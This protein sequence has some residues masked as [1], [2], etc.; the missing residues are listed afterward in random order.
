MHFVGFK[1]LSILSLFVFLFTTYIIGQDLDGVRL[2]FGVGSSIYWGS[3]MDTKIVTNTLGKSEIN[4]GL[5][6]QIYKSFDNINEFGIRFLSSELWS[7]KS[8]NQLALNNQFKELSFL[9]QRSLNQNVKLNNGPLTVNLLAGVGVLYYSASFYTINNNNLRIF[10]SIGAG[11]KPVSD[12]SF[13]IKEKIP[14]ISGIIG[15]NLGFK[16]S[17]RL[18]LYLENS[19]SLS[20]DN[21]FTGNLSLKSKVPNNGFTYH[22]LSLYLNWGNQKGRIGCPKF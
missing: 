11:D 10:S 17:P 21:R 2:G 5:N 7:F 14:A 22:A 18:L 19:F 3:Q 1:K 4:S 16:L 13:L 9:Y 20:L 12:P 15:L 6:F 8:N